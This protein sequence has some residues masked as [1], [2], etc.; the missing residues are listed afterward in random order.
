MFHSLVEGLISGSCA[1]VCFWNAS[2]GYNCSQLSLQGTCTSVSYDSE[3]QNL[4]SSFRNT[5]SFSKP[6]HT[7]F[8]QKGPQEIKPIRTLHSNSS[9]P[10]QQQVLARSLIFTLSSAH[11]IHPS[12]VTKRVVVA[13]GDE[14]TFQVTKTKLFLNYLAHDL[15]CEARKF[16]TNTSCSFFPDFR[17]KTFRR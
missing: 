7:V 11:T 10:I 9:A 2:S 14:T 15:G 13:A 5:P 8:E 6:S 17:H 3:S 16:N 12:P 1:G 4:L